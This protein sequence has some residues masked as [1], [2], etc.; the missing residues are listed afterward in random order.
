[1]NIFDFVT[2]DEIE[3]APT[4]DPALAFTQLVM[5]A[6]RRLRE[7]IKLIAPQDQAEFEEVEDARHG[8]MNFVLGLSKTLNIKPFSEMD[9]PRLDKFDTTIHR[10]FQ[11]DL[12]HYMTQLIIGNSMK[13]KANSVRLS[14][15]AKENILKY[16]NAIRDSLNMENIDQNHRETLLRKLDEFEIE[17]NKGRVSILA[18][19]L[20]ILA[21][22]GAPGSL[23]STYDIV[24]KL[25]TNILRIIAQEKA[26][27]DDTKR[28]HI[29]TTPAA[30]SPPRKTE[31]TTTNGYGLTAN[32]DDEI[33]F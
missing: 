6:Q 30:L 4:D 10:Q 12:D 16:V 8:F 24:S 25:S 28:L 32:L 27:D 26:S 18:S 31:E 5:H 29:Q 7:R 22:L 19:S 9:M 1:M 17:I 2:Q 13:D 15:T 3:S 11:A 23:S 33:P 20:V 14:S 21:L